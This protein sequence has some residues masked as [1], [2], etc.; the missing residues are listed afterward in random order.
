MWLELLNND[1]ALVIRFVLF[2]WAFLLLLFELSFKKIAYKRLSEN[3]NIFC[4]TS[5]LNTDASRGWRPC[6]GSRF[7]GQ[8]RE[9]SRQHAEG[10]SSPA[11]GKNGPGAVAQVCV[12][13]HIG[14]VK[15]EAGGVFL[16]AHATLGG[17][18]TAL[19]I[20]AHLERSCKGRGR[21]ETERPWWLLMKLNKKTK[22]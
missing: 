19:L 16:A 22:T 10:N 8:Q 2:C 11:E 6:E 12:A 4:Q 13:A 17:D 21:S 20:H 15:V 9:D 1:T 5:S 3:Y 7:S 14:V 18:G